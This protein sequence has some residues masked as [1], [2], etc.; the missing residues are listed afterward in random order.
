[1][2]ALNSANTTLAGR[3][4]WLTSGLVAVQAAVGVILVVATTLMLASLSRLTAPL[5]RTRRRQHCRG[6]RRH[7]PDP[8]VGAANRRRDNRAVD[9][10]VGRAPGRGLGLAAPPGAAGARCRCPGQGAPT[11]TPLRS[12]STG[13][14]RDGSASGS[15]WAVTSRRSTGPAR[16]RWRSSARRSPG[17]STEASGDRRDR[18]RRS[19]MPLTGGRAVRS[20]WWGSRP[21]SA[22]RRRGGPA[23][24]FTCRSRRSRPRRR[25]RGCT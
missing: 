10:A 17:A 3:H 8:G 19:M 11:P 7:R 22:P 9:C 4:Q 15:C 20:R 21:T 18:R 13:I 1:M 24:R 5:T 2:E 16:P 12:I 6:A 23:P 14:F 25:D